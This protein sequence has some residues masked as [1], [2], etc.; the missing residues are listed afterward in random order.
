MDSHEKFFEDK[1]PDRSKFYSSLEDECISNRNYLHA[2]NVWNVLKM[3]TLG[4]YHDLHLKTQ[5]SYQLMFLKHS[6]V[7]PQNIMDQI[8]IL[9]FL[10]LDQ[11]GMQCLK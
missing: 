8:L 6:L 7:H 5:F 10:A 1:L 9:I 3:N 2:N 4:D 11:V